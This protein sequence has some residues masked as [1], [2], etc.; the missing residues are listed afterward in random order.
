MPIWARRPTSRK[1][2]ISDVSS[3]SGRLTGPTSPLG[4]DGADRES[5]MFWTTGREVSVTATRTRSEESCVNSRGRSMIDVPL[6][7]SPP[8]E[9]WSFS[10]VLQ[11]THEANS[12]LKLT[13]AHRNHR[14]FQRKVVIGRLGA[15]VPE[16][17]SENAYRSQKPREPARAFMVAED[18]AGEATTW[19]WMSP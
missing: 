4:S 15:C 14:D 11:S 3:N 19:A 8:R 9:D 7:S 5:T 2:K 16:K 10:D 18:E 12:K 17:G 6:S 13:T 1:V